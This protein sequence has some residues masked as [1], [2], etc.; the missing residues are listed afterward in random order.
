MNDKQSKYEGV[1][2]VAKERVSKEAPPSPAPVSAA[3]PVHTALPLAR[4]GS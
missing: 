4:G 1:M 2:T 3:A